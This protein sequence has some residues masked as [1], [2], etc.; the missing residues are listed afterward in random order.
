MVH[1]D[2][3]VTANADDVVE[4]LVGVVVQKVLIDGYDAVAAV[5]VVGVASQNATLVVH[6]D[7]VAVFG[8]SLDVGAEGAFVANGVLN[9]A[10][11]AFVVVVDG[12]SE[13][14]AALLV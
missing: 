8:D 11:V 13:G 2:D 4:P 1:H 9:V 6:E 10:A 7:E 3:E 5:V 14:R 12:D